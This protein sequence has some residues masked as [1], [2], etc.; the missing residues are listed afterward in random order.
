MRSAT[1]YQYKGG[2]LDE[3][4]YYIERVLN[5]DDIDYVPKRA[6]PAP[7]P[8]KEWGWRTLFKDELRR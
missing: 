4:K 7:T 3:Q 8:V 5:E 1:G 6:Y 2:A